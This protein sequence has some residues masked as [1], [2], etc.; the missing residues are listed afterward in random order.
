MTFGFVDDPG[1]FL[2]QRQRDFQRRRPLLTARL[3]VLVESQSYGSFRLIWL[4]ARVPSRST[5]RDLLHFSRDV[6]IL[7]RVAA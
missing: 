1:L 3:T 2:S 7:V 6:L 5:L 4:P